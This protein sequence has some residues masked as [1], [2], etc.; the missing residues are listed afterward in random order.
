[1]SLTMCLRSLLL[2]WTDSMV[3]FASDAGCFSGSGSGSAF[4]GLE[5]LVVKISQLVSRYRDHVAG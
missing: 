1:M 3:C 2:G 4:F 5:V